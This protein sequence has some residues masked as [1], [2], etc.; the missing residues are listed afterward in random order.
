MERFRVGAEFVITTRP[1]GVPPI[2]L[3]YA[4]IVKSKDVSMKFDLRLRMV[5][6]AAQ[7]G[8]KPTAREFGCTV[9][10]VR[11]WV[12]RH[13][14][15]KGKRA[16]LNDRS[17]APKTCP[18]KTP[19]NVERQIIRERKKAPCLGARRLKRFCEIPASEGAIARILRQQGLTRRRKKKYQKKRDMRAIKARYK[20]F[21]QL[22][23][24]TKYLNDIPFYVEQWLRHSDLPR[25]QYTCRDVKTGAVFL[26]FARELSEAYACCFMAAVAAH[27]R[28]TGYDLKD[29]AT[30]QTDN[31]SEYSGNERKLR[32]DRGFRHLVEDTIK[33]RHRFIPVGKKNYQA[34]V[35]SLHERV[36]SEFFD[37]ELFGGRD[38]FFDR[39]S[40]WQL[41]WNTVRETGHRGNRSPDQI[42]CE[43]NA[44][45]DPNVWFLPALDLDQLM[46]RRASPGPASKKNP[47]GYYVP[48][49]P[50]STG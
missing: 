13:E 4:R 28:R 18:H 25:F 1:K 27:L 26:G 46:D 10:T 14:Q 44:Q 21:E 20:A 34:D 50:E 39:A 31:G 11:K 40:A 2:T 29:F 19:P 41:W 23:V 9:K 33:A 24:D 43:Q 12:R 32:N 36:E 45:R 48:A 38:D 15:D 7:H 49:L 6:Y 30:V 3:T 17:R 22:Q 47:G 42:L 35:E 8:I 37:L 5:Q 16:A